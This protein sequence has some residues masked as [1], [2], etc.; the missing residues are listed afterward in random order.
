MYE[1]DQYFLLN[2]HSKI[3]IYGAGER[4]NLLKDILFKKGFNVIGFFDQQLELKKDL[5][6]YSLSDSLFKDKGNIIIII[7]LSN[8]I[9]HNKICDDLHKKGFSKLV[10]LPLK[11]SIRFDIVKNMFG[12]YNKLISNIK[13]ENVKLPTY[14][15]FKNLKYSVESAIIKDLGNEI[16]VWMNYQIVYSLHSKEWKLDRDK[17]LSNQWFHN[18]NIGMFTSMIHLM[19]Y[20]NNEQQYYGL[21]LSQFNNLERVNYKNKLN[22][23]EKLFKLYQ[24]ELNFGMDFF[25]LSAPYVEKNEKGYFNLLDGHHRIIFLYIMNHIYFPVKLM[26]DDFVE[27]VNQKKLEEVIQYINEIGI[28]ELITPIPH[29]AFMDFPVKKESIGKTILSTIFEELSYMNLHEASIL[30]CSQYQGYF[31]RNLRPMVFGDVCCIDKHIQFTK[32]LNELVR[33]KNIDLINDI[34]EI[35]YQCNNKYDIIFMMDSMKNF[36]HKSSKINYIKTLNRLTNKKLFWES[37]TNLI[38]IEINEI[39]QYTDFLRYKKIHTYFDN[40][41]KIEVGYFSYD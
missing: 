41:K 27:W 32:L 13:I 18:K 14:N 5:P 17:I 7:S 23:R 37:S 21:Y 6:V 16:V 9:L 33:S 3:I 28:T 1:K 25:K 8:G 40:N 36:E 38:E 2:K 20:F 34:D 22:E 39:F 10:F 29:P 35:N 11:Y 15:A 30:D 26:K 4:G 31:A 12:F 19:R 24:K